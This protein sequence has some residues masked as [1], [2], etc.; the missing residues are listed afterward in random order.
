M[1]T[2]LKG[3]GLENFRVFK[4]YTWFDFA[5]ITVLTG[6]NNSGKSS[7]IKALLLTEENT[8]QMLTGT[9]EANHGKHNLGTFERMLNDTQK[10]VSFELPFELKH[11]PRPFNYQSATLKLTYRYQPTLY[12]EDDFSDRNPEELTFE[13]LALANVQINVNN[14]IL[15]EYGDKFKN[16]VYFDKLFFLSLLK[17]LPDG[18]ITFV[19]GKVKVDF[20]EIN[21]NKATTHIQAKNH[22]VYIRDSTAFC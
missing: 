8:K 14:K 12:R 3:F 11:I 5:P 1:N 4:D 7:L 19:D 6:P 18:F 16:F 9:F 22:E 2:H 21:R 15:I 10:D 20:K 17:P 13:H